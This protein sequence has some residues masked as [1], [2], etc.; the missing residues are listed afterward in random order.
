M[1]E[2][3]YERKLVRQKTLL[4]LFPFSAAFWERHRWAKT[5]P[6]FYKTGQS[7][8]Y[9]LSEVESWLQRNRVDTSHG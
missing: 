3:K 8:L 5:G 4:E 2:G 1:N 9:D 7:V 6:N